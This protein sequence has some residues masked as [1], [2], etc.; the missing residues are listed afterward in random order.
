MLMGILIWVVGLGRSD[1]AHATSSLSR[2]SACS[3][4][5][6]LARALHVFGFLK[7][8][9]NR[10]YV[11]NSRDPILRGDGEALGKDFMQELG[12]LYPDATEE[13]DANLPTSLVEEIS[14]TVFVDSDHGHNKV[15]RI[16]I[17]GLIAFLGWT[18]A[19]YLS[20]RQGAI[21]TST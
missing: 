4:E 9:P 20:K 14:I 12:A 8:R 1:V 11:V 19:F 5:G 17:T 7:K 15:T 16:S 18:P 2:L 21:E 6:H 3:R 13:L 10:I